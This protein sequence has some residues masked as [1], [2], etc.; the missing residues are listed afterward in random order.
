MPS[1]IDRTT[2]GRAV[3]GMVVE[4]EFLIAM[5]LQATLE[6]HGYRVVGPAAAVDQALRLIEGDR[7][8]AALL[9][10]NLRGEIVTPVAAALQRAEVPFLLASAYGAAELARWGLDARNL[11]KPVE[12]ERLLAALAEIGC[13]PGTSP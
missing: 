2:T 6:Q 1:G 10:V 8:D 4:D 3:S 7:P 5:S 13:G 11:G 12:P 9:D